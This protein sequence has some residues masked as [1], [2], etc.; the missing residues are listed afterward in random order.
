M[1][2]FFLQFL[3]EEHFCD[4]FS[5]DHLDAE[6]LRLL[7]DEIVGTIDLA[8]CGVLKNWIKHENMRCGIDSIYEKEG[9]RQAFLLNLA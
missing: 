9:F 4:G 1:A 6:G 5:L 7:C 8:Y 2:L 3:Q